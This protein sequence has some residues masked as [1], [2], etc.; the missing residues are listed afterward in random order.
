MRTTNDQ[1]N[2]MHDAPITDADSVQIDFTCKLGAPGFRGAD[3][4][5]LEIRGQLPQWPSWNARLCT[6][7]PMICRIKCRRRPKLGPA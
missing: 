3:D 4:S 1:Q 7:S 5:L 2:L 6:T